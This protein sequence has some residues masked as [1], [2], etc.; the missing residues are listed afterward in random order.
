MVPQ[1]GQLSEEMAAEEEYRDKEV[2]IEKAKATVKEHF[3]AEATWNG[4]HENK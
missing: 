2:D 1:G 3:L 4:L